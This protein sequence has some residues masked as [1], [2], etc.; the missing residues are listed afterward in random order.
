MKTVI[1][2]NV[3]VTKFAYPVKADGINPKPGNIWPRRQTICYIKHGVTGT[4]ELPNKLV[5]VEVV[6]SK[7]DQFSR[8]IG[9]TLAFKK[10]LHALFADA[11]FRKEFALTKVEFNQ[12]VNDFK[13]QCSNS[14]PL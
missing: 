14:V 3:F 8:K 11:Y 12:F 6:N 1:G 7:K 10:A 13:E 4:T 9:R 2:N 5:E